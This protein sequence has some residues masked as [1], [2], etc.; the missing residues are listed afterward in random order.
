MIL[1]TIESQ[2]Q[3]Y[4]QRNPQETPLYKII[5]EHFG[6]FKEVYE[7]RFQEKYGYWRSCIQK[8]AHKTF[9]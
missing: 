5:E 7:A 8:F 4:S 9:P 1:E 3:V 6:E 2:N